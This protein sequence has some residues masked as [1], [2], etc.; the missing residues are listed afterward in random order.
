MIVAVT[1]TR[2]FKNVSDFDEWVAHH[3][4][5]GIDR[6]AIFDDSTAFDLKQASAKYEGRVDYAKAT[7]REQ[8]KLYSDFVSKSKADWVLP[9]DDDEYLWIDNRFK[10]I[11]DVLNHYERKL[12]TLYV[13]GIRWKYLFPKKFHSERNC[14]VLSY[15]TEENDWLAT[16]FSGHGNRVIKCMVR[17]SAFERYMDAD[18]SRLRNHIPVSNMTNGA[19]LTD[20]TLAK[21]QIVKPPANEYIRLIHCPFKGYS[22]YMQKRET[23]YSVCDSKHNKR[24]YAFDLQLENLE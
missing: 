19:T 12:G 24:R 2:R 23:L 7:T 15:C 13:F 14:N 9:L 18:E 16:R 11:Q 4:H 10:T 20:G 22:D 17:P 3:L 8:Y 6:I 21:V 5:I 1:L